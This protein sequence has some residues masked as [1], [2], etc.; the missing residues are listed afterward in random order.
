MNVTL[1][2]AMALGFETVKQCTEH[3]EW[4]I[5]KSQDSFTS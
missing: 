4:L 3:Q 1:D 5:G 2:E